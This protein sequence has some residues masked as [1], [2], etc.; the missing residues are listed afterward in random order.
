MSDS[1]SDSKGN[2]TDSKSK[3]K[4]S[5]YPE[6]SDKDFYEKLFRKKEFNMFKIPKETR[7]MEEICN[8]ESYELM[9]QQN[10]LKNYISPNT[11]YNAILIYHGT[12]VG[13]TCTGITI[14]EN[15]KKQ[16]KEQSKRVLI[17]VSSD[18]ET[19]FRNEIYDIQKEL[20]KKPYERDLLV[21]C[22]GE[23]YKM[24]EDDL[25]Y[26]SIKQLR[27][28]MRSN[29]NKNYQFMAYRKLA[30][31]IKRQT[32][33]NGDETLITEKVKNI[34]KRIYSNRVIIIDE[35]Q[36]IRDESEVD[37]MIPPIIE[38]MVKYSDNVKLII[39]S[40]TPMYH[41]PREIVYILNLMLSVDKRPPIK[42]EDIFDKS[43]N[44]TEKGR[45]ILN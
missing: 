4:Y 23:A 10:F 31:Q 26:L 37:K 27:R 21:Q 44:I 45:K 41:S 14:A 40:A 35:V 22:T 28:K 30:N 6:L 7:E 8:P 16:M 3:I 11:P 2:V 1:V 9:P 20:D 19:N 36:N 18:I 15:F 12:G 13:K 5:Y 43:D 39:M 34:I 24:S 29:I 33:W 32:N 42:E 38:A 17:I 25:K